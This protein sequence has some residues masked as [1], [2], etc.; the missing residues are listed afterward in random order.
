MLFS[1]FLGAL[2]PTLAAAFQITPAGPSLTGNPYAIIAQRNIFGLNPPGLNTGPLTPAP[3]PVEIT[4]TGIQSILGQVSALY[5]VHTPPSPGQPASDQYYNLTKGQRQDDIE[6]VNIDPKSGVIT[7]NNHG[8]TEELTLTNAVS[9]GGGAPAPMSSGTSYHPPYGAA[10]NGP[11]EPANRFYRFGGRGNPARF[12][13]MNSGLENGAAGSPAGSQSL[14]NPFE[15]ASTQRTYQPPPSN[16][17]A[18]QLKTL[19]EV[20]RAALEASKH[21][22]YPPNLLPP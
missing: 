19:I 15:A 9:T 16:M 7:F 12:R 13:P 4:L 17:T 18:D 21:P 5:K 10:H 11:P 6:V 1:G 8:V 22:A 2:A 14:V 20:Q 3:P